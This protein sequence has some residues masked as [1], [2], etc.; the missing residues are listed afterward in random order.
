MTAEPLPRRD[1]RRNFLL[2]VVNGAVFRVTMVL[3]DTEN[4]VA[5][6]STLI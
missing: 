3:I 1:V 6:L 5:D 2:G 4:R